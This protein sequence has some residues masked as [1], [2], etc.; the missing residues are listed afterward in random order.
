MRCAW[1]SLMDF[2]GRRKFEMRFTVDMTLHIEERASIFHTSTIERLMKQY[3]TEFRAIVLVI[4]LYP[5][6]NRTA[7]HNGQCKR[8]IEI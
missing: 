5:N 2:W 1:R 8:P 6:M 7:H 4:E 3:A